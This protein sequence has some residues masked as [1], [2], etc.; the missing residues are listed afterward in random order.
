MAPNIEQSFQ[1][2]TSVRWFWAK[3]RR[4]YVFFYECKLNSDRAGESICILTSSPSKDLARQLDHF[5]SECDDAASFSI[6]W[7]SLACRYVL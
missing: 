5:Q 1:H 6:T 4:Q 7:Q 3:S 2:A